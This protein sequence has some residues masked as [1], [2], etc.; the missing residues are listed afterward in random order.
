MLS[1]SRAKSAWGRERNGPQNVE[2]TVYAYIHHYHV[3]A[4]GGSVE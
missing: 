3:F 2:W 4:G 1:T